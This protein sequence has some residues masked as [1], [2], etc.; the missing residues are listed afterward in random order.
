MVKSDLLNRCHP[1]CLFF[2]FMALSRTSGVC[3]LGEVAGV[4]IY[5]FYFF[6]L[7]FADDLVLFQRIR[8]IQVLLDKLNAYS[9]QN[10]A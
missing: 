4:S 6:F 10:G 3:E 1:Y 8:W 7:L 2:S 9:F 5:Q